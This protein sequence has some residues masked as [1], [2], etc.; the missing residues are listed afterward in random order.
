MTQIELFKSKYDFISN[1]K[2]SFNGFAIEYNDLLF[3]QLVVAYA[4]KCKRSKT[5]K[6]KK[7]DFENILLK[8]EELNK[9]DKCIKQI[10]YFNNGILFYSTRISPFSVQNVI[11][12]FNEA[13]RTLIYAIQKDDFL[14]DK[15]I[16]LNDILIA[17]FDDKS[18]ESN[19][20][21]I[22]ETIEKEII[23]SKKDVSTVTAK[24]KKKKTVTAEYGNTSKEDTTKKTSGS[25]KNDS[26]S[27]DKETLSDKATKK[28][29]SMKKE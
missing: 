18:T 8:Q 4:H 21:I 2:F 26:N 29:N 15:S 28:L 23:M 1:R 3:N 24:T 9:D 25:K 20:I 17:D 6:G 7:I 11:D 10:I 27:K 14:T 5:W 19:D 16:D 13:R 22:S 12:A